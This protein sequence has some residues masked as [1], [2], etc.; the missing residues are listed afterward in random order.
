MGLTLGSGFWEASPGPGAGDKGLSLSPKEHL[1]GAGAVLPTQPGSARGQEERN[2][3]VGS[4]CTHSKSQRA[5]NWEAGAVSY[6]GNQGRKKEYPTKTLGE[7][8]VSGFGPGVTGCR[9]PPELPA[10]VGLWGEGSV[11][12]SLLELS[13]SPLPP[14]PVS[15]TGTGAPR[16]AGQDAEAKCPRGCESQAM[17]LWSSTAQGPEAQPRHRHSRGGSHREQARAKYRHETARPPS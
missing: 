7:K 10:W 15:P 4:I 1:Q 16:A 6:K 17:Q 13:A 8:D 11:L 5:R 2:L 3:D 12:L 14:P 9:Q